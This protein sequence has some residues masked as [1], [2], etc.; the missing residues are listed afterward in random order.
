MPTGFLGAMGINRET[1][2]RALFDK[3]TGRIRHAERDLCLVSLQG[4]FPCSRASIVRIVDDS[5][6][7]ELARHHHSRMPDPTIDLTARQE[8]LR[9]ATAY[10]LELSRFIKRQ[11]PNADDAQDIL[12]ELYLAILKLHGLEAIRHPKAYL[13]R[14]A[15]NLAHQ[16][17]ERHKALPP[18]T[19]LDEA[20]ADALQTATSAFEVN[21]PESAAALAERIAQIERRLRELSPK[22]QAA[23]VLH[24]R[25]GYTCEE[26]SEKLAVVRHRVKKYLVKGLAH[27][28]STCTVAAD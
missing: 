22:V 3:A 11:I 17:R 12:Q 6:A 5:A 27:C 25:D 1:R 13:F 10:A 19:T 23:V 18:H 9:S 15:A 2:R 24:H 7:R 8:L 16:H 20:A 4:E 21:T 14:I 26:V 28:R